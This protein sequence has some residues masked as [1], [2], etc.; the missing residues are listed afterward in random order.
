MRKVSIVLA[1]VL[2]VYMSCATSSPV[3]EKNQKGTVSV[4]NLG[5]ADPL[6]P[7]WTKKFPA[8][9]GYYVGIGSSNTG[10]EAEDLKTAEERARANIASAIST[11]IHEEVNI[12][13]KDSSTGASFNYAEDRVSAEVEQ[14]LTGVETVDTY[15]SKDAGAWVYMRLSKALWE[16]TQKKE[17]AVLISRI[18]NFLGP[19]LDDYNRPFITRVQQLVKARKLILESPYPGMLK[20]VFYGERGSLIDIIDSFL[21]EHLDSLYIKTTPVAADLSVGKSLKYSV[22]LTTS[23]AS[24]VGSVP[25]EIINSSDTDAHVFSG[26]TDPDGKYSGELKYTALAMG[27]NHLRVLPDKKAIG[28][29]ETFTSL[30]LPETEMI[31]DLQGI[32]VG[33]RVVLPQGMPVPG[34]KGAVTS[35][36]SRKDL[37]F[38]VD[39][40]AKNISPVIQFEFVIT[41]F[42]KAMEGAPAMAQI[43]AVISL[44]KKG[45]NVYSYASK[46]VKDGGI[47]PDQAHKRAADKLMKVLSNDDTYVQ[48]ILKALA[49]N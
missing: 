15:S 5:V 21:K 28:I 23:V 22:A 20:T 29:D 33:L 14:S 38:K 17:M 36:F 7:L 32:T 40:R 13:T 48:E 16:K 3:T 24:R 44:I 9:A 8:E 47:T 1:V 42:P 35:L 12:I 10:N 11:K 27:K 46:P 18:T 6:R 45:K 43:S 39:S 19:V 2:T 49:L 30:I 31:V 4:K 34:I 37:P 41:D 25:F 26:V